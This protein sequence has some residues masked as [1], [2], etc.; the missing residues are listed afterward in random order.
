[1]ITLPQ[2]FNDGNEFLLGVAQ[3]LRQ[4]FFLPLFVFLLIL[5]LVRFVG[6]FI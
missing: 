1:M 5:Y 3:L 2:V 4:E 6:R